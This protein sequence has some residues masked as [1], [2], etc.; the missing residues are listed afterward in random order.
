VLI[1]KNQKNEL[2]ATV[3]LWVQTVDCKD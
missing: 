2:L 1:I 3:N